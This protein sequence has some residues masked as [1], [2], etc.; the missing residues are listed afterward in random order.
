M[1][2][3]VGSA[4]GHAAALILHDP[5]IDPAAFALV[6]MGTFYGGIA[7]APLSALVLVS[8]LAGSYDLFVPM[9]LAVSLAFVALRSWT[10]YSAQ[11]STKADSPALQ[12]EAPAREMDPMARLCAR[13]LLFP[14]EVPPVREEALA[15]RG[16]WARLAQALS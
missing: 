8:E 7:H 3:L 5:R 10:L 4:F 11:P 14:V 12:A 13:D 2:G 6:G 9:M 16:T 1:G 15:A